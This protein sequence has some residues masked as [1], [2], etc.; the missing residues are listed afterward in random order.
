MN[1]YINLPQPLAREDYEEVVNA[2][3]EKLKTLSFV[4]AAYLAGGNWVPGI[5]DIDVILVFFDDHTPHAPVFSPRS[6]SEKASYCFTHNFGTYNEASF[7]RLFFI[8]PDLTKLECRLGN[9]VSPVDPRTELSGEEY[10][11]LQSSIIFDLVA[12]KLWKMLLYE[13]AQSI[14]VRKVLGEFY[15][16]T[17]TL[18]L[19]ERIGVVVD[20][21]G[22]AENI[23]GLR[24]HWFRR[25]ER[26]NLKLLCESMEHGYR[27]ILH[28]IEEL[29]RRV[30][31]LFP[32]LE[33]GAPTHFL[34]GT[35]HLEF[36]A[37]W[38]AE[39][40][41]NALQSDCV[42]VLGRT[43]H[44]VL[45]PRSLA[46]YLSVYGSEA[47]PF[48]AAI[49]KRLF[50]PV[51]VRESAWARAIGIHAGFLGSLWYA[52]YRHHGSLKVPFHFGIEPKPPTL[53]RTLRDALFIFLLRS[54]A[55]SI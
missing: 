51:E 5:S 46:L 33:K 16:L 4:K 13:R 15:S 10:E 21:G 30:A 18:R 3:V 19:L 41:R 9:E 44:H 34:S 37:M 14:D 35:H 38:S 48:G 36:T 49:R 52:S 47:T 53:R 29:G 26:E 1:I 45:L 7:R 12:T 50:S 32:E 22:Y 17:Y 55:P 8:I 40:M 31:N 43:Q 23:T 54:H 6:V 27:I 24:N 25:S 39:R 11:A 2:V 20:E 28:S 42:T